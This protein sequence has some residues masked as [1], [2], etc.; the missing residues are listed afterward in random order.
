ME[1]KENQESAELSKKSGKDRKQKRFLQK[2]VDLL[3]GKANEPQPEAVR[4]PEGYMDTTL[5]R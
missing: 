4:I 5:I 2:H 1:V 3:K